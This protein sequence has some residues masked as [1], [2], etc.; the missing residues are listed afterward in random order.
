MKYAVVFLAFAAVCVFAAT[1]TALV[2]LQIAALWCA[3]AFGGVGLAYAFLGPRALRQAPGRNISVMEPH[4]LRALF[5]AQRAQ[6]M[7]ISA[8]REARRA[9]ERFR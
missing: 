2:P 9:R 7:G 1:Q 6:F 5:R 8:Q 4:A 3:L